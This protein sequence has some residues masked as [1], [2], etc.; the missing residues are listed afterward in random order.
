MGRLVGAGFGTWLGVQTVINVGGVT[1]LLPI[2]GLPLP[3]VS[4]GGTSIIM[5]GIVV[6]ILFVIEADNQELKDLA[7]IDEMT[8]R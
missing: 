4:Y 2:T 6:G 3:F 1:G 5:M 7:K 8:V